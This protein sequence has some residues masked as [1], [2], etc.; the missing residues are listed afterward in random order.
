MNNA[1]LI[2]RLYQGL[3]DLD[4]E[5][6]AACYSPDARFEDPAF[7]VLTGEQV[8]GMWRMLTARSNRRG[9]GRRGR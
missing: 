4:G 6:M 5:A 9:R 8:G 2:E 7:G 3:R 1:D